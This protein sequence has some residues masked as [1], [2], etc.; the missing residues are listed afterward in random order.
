MYMVQIVAINIYIKMLK[1]FISYF[2]SSKI[3]L[4]QFMDDHC[5]CYITKMERKKHYCT[6]TY[7][8]TNMFI[9]NV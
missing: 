2:V 6:P 4:N 1:D 9:Y 5:L 7:L 3:C 8:T